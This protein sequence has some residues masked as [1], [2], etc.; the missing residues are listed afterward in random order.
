M[1]LVV[2]ALPSRVGTGP[3]PLE[4]TEEEEDRRGIVEF[5]VTPGRRRRK[6]SGISWP[7]LEEAVLLNGPT[8]LALTFCDHLDADVAG[9]RNRAD[10]TT[11]V[12]QL[13]DELEMRR[14]LRL[15]QIL[16]GSRRSQLNLLT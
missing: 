12:R 9:A 1:V 8:Q 3:L 5:G 4:L 6:A 10:L 2:K 14:A 11:P 15:R 7:H 16:R 13:I